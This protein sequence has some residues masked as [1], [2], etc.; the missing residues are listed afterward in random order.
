M[1][2]MA[3]AIARGYNRGPVGRMTVEL[4]FSFGGSKREQTA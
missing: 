3:L 2:V 4:N 1:V